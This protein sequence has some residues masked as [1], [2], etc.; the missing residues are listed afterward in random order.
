METKQSFNQMKSPNDGQS[1]EDS[2]M[3]TQGT[4]SQRAEPVDTA[5]EYRPLV[6]QQQPATQQNSNAQQQPRDDGAQINEMMK[7]RQ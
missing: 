2:K 1:Q 3:A 6:L 4:L 7:Y 5:A